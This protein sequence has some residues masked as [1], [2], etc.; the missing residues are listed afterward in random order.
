MAC[1]ACIACGE[2]IVCDG[3]AACCGRI[4]CCGFTACG[5]RVPCG[6]FI[7]RPLW[8]AGVGR[9]EAEFA[10]TILVAAA[11]GVDVAI[12]GVVAFVIDC[13]FVLTALAGIIGAVAA[14]SSSFLLALTTHSFYHQPML[15]S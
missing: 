3:P 12:A 8:T 10:W 14:L 11:V 7:G 13:L 4:A 2:R 6:G 9:R 1:C 5:G 15:L